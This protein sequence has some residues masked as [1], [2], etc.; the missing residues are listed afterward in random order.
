M[1]GLWLGWIVRFG[2]LIGGFGGGGLVVELVGAGFVFL[3]PGGCCTACGFVV[4]CG[5][6]S[7]L[8]LMGVVVGHSVRFVLAE[9]FEVVAFGV[10]VVSVGLGISV[11]RGW[12]F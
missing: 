1:D 11:G 8:V 7:C 9:K 12:T 2:F 5:G 4:W 10:L 6:F 3:A